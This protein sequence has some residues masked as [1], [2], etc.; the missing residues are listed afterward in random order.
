[1]SDIYTELQGHHLSKTVFKQR[2]G[3]N[4]EIQQHDF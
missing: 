2:V 1:M 3:I 4:T